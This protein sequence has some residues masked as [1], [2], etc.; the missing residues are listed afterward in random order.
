MPLNLQ[1]KKKII[2]LGG[3]VDPDYHGEIG[4]LRH[5][6]GKSGYVW[7]AGDALENLL[8][9]L[10]PVIKVNGKLQQSNPSRMKRHRYFLDEDMVHSRE[11]SKTC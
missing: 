2:V 9:L 10:Y 4:L 1:D 11:I 7:S 8:M 6:G 3:F 5:N